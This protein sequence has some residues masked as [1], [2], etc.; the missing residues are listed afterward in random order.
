M[1]NTLLSLNKGHFAKFCAAVSLT[2]VDLRESPIGF[3]NPVIPTKILSQSCNPDGLYWP[4]P[5][6]II[7]FCLSPFPKLRRPRAFRVGDDF[8]NQH[9]SVEVY[10]HRKALAFSLVSLFSVSSITLFT[11]MMI[12]FILEVFK[13]LREWHTPVKVT[14]FF[15]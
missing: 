7:Q 14:T 13:A 9:W 11:K 4:I 5:M 1:K 8:L 12:S 6:T 2:L 3:F 15:H 10:A